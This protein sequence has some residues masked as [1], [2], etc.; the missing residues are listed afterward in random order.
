MI[1]QWDYQRKKSLRISGTTAIG[2]AVP[3]LLPLLFQR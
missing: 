3:F 1:L 2:F